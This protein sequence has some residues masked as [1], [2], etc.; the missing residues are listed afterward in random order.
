MGIGTQRD[1]TV[2]GYRMRRVVI[3]LA[4]VGLSVV[5][6][7]ASAKLPFFSFDVTPARPSVGEPITVT[8]RC[9]DDERHRRLLPSC[10]GAGATM[11]WVHPLDNEGHLDRRDWIQVEG[12][13]T[14]T[15]AT[16]GEIKL[17]EAGA[18]LLVPLWRDWGDGHGQGFPDAIQIEVAPRQSLLSLAAASAAGLIAMWFAVAAGTSGSLDRQSRRLG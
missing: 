3:A 15:G 11:A 18:Y 2:Y 10:L 6:G 17:D 1:S 13:G 4:I 7:V 5:P 9:F 12:R 16:R 14:P 8:M